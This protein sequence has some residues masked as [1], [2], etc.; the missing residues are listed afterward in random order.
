MKGYLSFSLKLKRLGLCIGLCIVDNYIFATK[1]NN[2]TS[3]KSYTYEMTQDEQNCIINSLPSIPITFEMKPQLEDIIVKLTP[4]TSFIRIL[5]LTIHDLEGNIFIRWSSRELEDSKV[6]VIST[7][8]KLILRSSRFFNEIGVEYVELVTLYNL[9]WGIVHVV[10]S[11]IVFVPLKPSVH[12][13]EVPGLAG[14]VLVR[15]KVLL[16]VE[17]GF[18]AELCFITERKRKVIIFQC[19]LNLSV[20]ISH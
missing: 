17:F 18:H 3:K 20:K 13:V 15:P 11:L 10:V 14:T 4:K 8:N 9:G 6:L 1:I 7:R 12:S 16:S 2:C 5:P 19:K